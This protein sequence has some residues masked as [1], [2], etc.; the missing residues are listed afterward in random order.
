[1][2]QIEIKKIIPAFSDERGAISDIV[3]DAV[4]LHV[5]IITSKAGTIRANHYHIKQTQHNYILSGKVKLI[6]W[7]V[8]DPKNVTKNI[9][10][11]CDLVFIPAGV[12]HRMEFLEDTVFLDMNSESRSNDGYEKDTVRVEYDSSL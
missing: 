10:V 9:L 11:P 7:Q 5:G 2:N 8:K 12:A 6:T 3:D 4:I 1:M